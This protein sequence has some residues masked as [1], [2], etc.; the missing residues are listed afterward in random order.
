M[1]AQFMTVDALM[2]VGCM[3]AGKEKP[4]TKAGL[5]MVIVDVTSSSEDRS[6]AML[7]SAMTTLG[8]TAVSVRV[9]PQFIQLIALTG[10]SLSTGFLQ[11]P[12][13]PLTLVEDGLLYREDVIDRVIVAL[14]GNDFLLHQEGEVEGIER[15]SGRHRAYA[16]VDGFVD[17]ANAPPLVAS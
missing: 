13:D 16:L 4:G 9:R 14:V 12:A 17:W 2:E 10:Y 8:F 1:P 11:A 3:I 15:R 6:K 7:R 5:L